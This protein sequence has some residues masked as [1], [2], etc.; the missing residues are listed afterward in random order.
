MNITVLDPKKVKPNP[1]QPRLTMNPAALADLAT[2]IEEQGLQSPP[3]VRAVNGH[4]ELAF[5]HRR[6]EA[7]KI[8]KPG[9]HFPAFIV[10]L[11]DQQMAELAATENSQRAD[12]NPIE[13]AKALQRLIADFGMTQEKAGKLFGLNTQGAVS[14]A[15]RLLKLPAGAQEVVASGALAERHARM[16]VAVS[17][18]NAKEAERIAKRV[19]KVDPEDRDQEISEEVED[20]FEEHAIKLDDAPFELA[21]PAKPITTADAAVPTIPACK[22]CPHN[23]LIK[24]EWNTDQRFCTHPARCYTL[25]TNAWTE[26][27]LRRVSDKL[28]IAIAKPDEKTYPFFAGDHYYNIG[29]EVRNLLKQA[30]VREQLRLT[31]WTAKGDKY[32]RAQVLGSEAVILVSTSATLHAE[33]LEQPKGSSKANAT[34]EAK[35]KAEEKAKRD[36]LLAQ[37]RARRFEHDVAWLVRSVTERAAPTLKVD[38]LPIALALLENMDSDYVDNDITRSWEEE[39]GSIAHNEK[40]KPAERLAAAQKLIAFNIVAP[41]TERWN[42]KWADIVANVTLLAQGK[43]KCMRL[44][45]KYFGLPMTLPKHWDVPPIHK[46]EGNCWHCGDFTASGDV[47]QKDIEAGWGVLSQGHQTLDIHCP[48]CSHSPISTEMPKGKKGKSK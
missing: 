45:S 9:E 38:S 4:Y 37:S 29:D 43:A 19:T 6:F 3:Q 18:F 1:Y 25:K 16:L 48:R 33:L 13:R 47:T 35:R 10:E 36:E 27:E 39:L 7:W 8:A 17:Q 14:N 31:A 40:G 34:P 20:V 30:K 15:L 24:S 42:D 22:G 5:G 46:T 28:K 11:T 21:W 44:N 2:S 32:G 41:L 26:H 23:M 12:L